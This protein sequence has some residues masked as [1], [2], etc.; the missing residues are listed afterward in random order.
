MTMPTNEPKT[1]TASPTIISMGN[2]KLLKSRGVKVF[3]GVVHMLPAREYDRLRV[4]IGWLPL[5]VNACAFAGMCKNLCI[6][7]TGRGHIPML[8]YAK[9]AFKNNVEHGRFRRSHAFYTDRAAFIAT[10]FKDMRRLVKNATKEGMIPAL[11][12]NGTSD[13]DWSR[14][15]PE[16][17]G[18]AVGLGITLYDY[19]KRPVT[20]DAESPVHHT[21]SVDVSPARV[22]RAV[23]YLQA[24]GNA[25]VVFA[26]PKGQALPAT[27][28]GF[29]V[30]DGDLT[31]ARFLD[32]RGVVVGLHA[33]GKAKRDRT[34][35]VYPNVAT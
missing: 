15:Y 35:F 5:G 7:T 6:N 25:A 34:G 3:S 14:D 11:R 23:A 28:N 29:P 16:V 20:F 32:P 17:V 9:S 18:Y 26:T 30:V 4:A 24:G 22:R 31:D 21:Y 10:L 2:P 27:W 12:L 1:L 33:K 13:I 19:T 8:S